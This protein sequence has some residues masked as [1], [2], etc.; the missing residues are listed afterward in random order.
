MIVTLLN[1]LYIG[2]TTFVLGWFAITRIEK[3]LNITNK[4]EKSLNLNVFDCL[5]GGFVAVTIY[6]ETFSIF[7]GLS[8]VANLIMVA[9]CVVIIIVW[10]KNI[11]VVFSNFLEKIKVNKFVLTGFSVITIAVFT[12]CL[13]YTAQ[14]TFHYDTGLYHAQAIHWLED[15]GLIKGLGRIHV[16]FAYNSAYLPICAIYSLKFI[17]GQSLHSVSG[18]LLALI[19]LYCIYGWLVSIHNKTFM[20][21]SA[22]SDMIRVAPFFYLLCIIL[23][24]TSPESDYVQ[25]V[26]FM[27]VILRF[28]EI[29]ERDNECVNA[30]ILVA[31][32]AIMVVSY[33]LSAAPIVLVALRPVYMLFK[34]KNYICIAI[35]AGMAVLILLPW[36]IRNYYICGW[37]IYPV[38]FIDIFNPVWKFSKEMVDGDASE[39]GAWAMESQDQA[40]TGFGWIRL[41]WRNQTKSTQLFIYSIVVSAPV[42]AFIYV[43]EFFTLIIAKKNSI[44]NEC[45]RARRISLLHILGMNVITLAFYM[46]TAPLIR[47]CYGP[48]L[49]LPAMVA[50]IL[51]S[52]ISDSSMK[53]VLK[54]VVAA[55]CALA[56]IVPSLEACKE[57]LIY[58]YEETFG[59]FDFGNTLVKQIDYPKADVIPIVWFGYTVY[60]PKEGDQCW[61]EAFPSSPYIE[62]FVYST[63]IGDELSDGV[64]ELEH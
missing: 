61:Y 58:N 59:R 35:C 30:Y 62:G 8:L 29:C 63:L 51:L 46:I 1:W 37:L 6:A 14:S 23:E 34:K 31:C 13:L 5:F 47:Y 12:L 39:I 20:R 48:V 15:Y 16:R 53:K 45:D 2:I 56:I 3:L 22:V 42:M 40:T 52:M 24:I 28:V 64:M 10:R 32:V 33:K 17:V 57:I 49:L 55:A 43:R 9:A 26:F 36:F 38:S 41:W 44:V 60:L 50:G 11:T 21:K 54:S 18:Y 7:G 25:V 19:C 4:A 27:W